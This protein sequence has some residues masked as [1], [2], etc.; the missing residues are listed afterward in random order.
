LRKFISLKKVKT[1]TDKELKI[2]VKS[3]FLT[4]ETTLA[5]SVPLHQQNELL[6]IKNK[7]P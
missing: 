4:L 1:D 5:G 7:K 2:V 6:T 3:R